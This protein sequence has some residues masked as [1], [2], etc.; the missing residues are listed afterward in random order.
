M[1]KT[2]DIQPAPAHGRR[3]GNANTYGSIAHFTCMVGYNAKGSKTR[4]CKADGKFS[5]EDFRCF[6]VAC[7]DPGAVENS[8][9][10]ATDTNKDDKDKL[11]FKEKITWTCDLGYEMA[12]GEATRTCGADGTWSGTKPVCRKQTCGAPQTVRFATNAVAEKDN[13]GTEDGKR[14]NLFGAVATYDCE[15]GFDTGKPLETSPDTLDCRV[16][17]KKHNKVG[18]VGVLPICKV[19]DCGR[20]PELFRP[21]ATKADTKNKVNGHF[22]VSKMTAGSLKAVATESTVG[23]IVTFACNTGYERKGKSKSKCQPDHRWSAAAPTCEPVP[24][25]QPEKEPLL[26]DEATFTGDNFFF[27]EEITLKCDVGFEFARFETKAGANRQAETTTRTCGA[28][29]TWSGPNPDCHPV[30]CG[31]LE[32]P[33][34][35]SMAGKNLGASKRERERERERERTESE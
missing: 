34:F 28:D 17:D 15:D 26:P 23:S 18:W 20:T 25:P 7:K 9:R 27:A 3:T 5:G 35:G 2:C 22:K 12:S 24:C 1:I 6:P 10:A 30:F 8:A 4:T 31:T 11:T 32:A 16:V 14:L 29:G 19:V 21:P 33:K 13:K